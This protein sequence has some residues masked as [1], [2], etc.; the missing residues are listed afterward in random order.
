MPEQDFEMRVAT[1]KLFVGNSR[2]KSVDPEQFLKSTSVKQIVEE[3]QRYGL[4]C[5]D[6]TVEGGPV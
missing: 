1:D 6:W 2:N 4:G 5:P 3:L